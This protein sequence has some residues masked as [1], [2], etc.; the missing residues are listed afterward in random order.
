MKKITL[1]L[2]VDEAFALDK[3]LN[4]VPG[5]VP[6]TPQGKAMKSICLETS[7]K[8]HK[9]VRKLQKDTDLFQDKKKTKIE[10]KYHEA[11]A[12]FELI[13]AFLPATG[14]NSNLQKINDFLHQKTLV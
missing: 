4:Q 11:Y 10:L 1:P 14:H 2:L 7:D 3:L 5:F 8:V 13:N 12:I 9:L 6:K